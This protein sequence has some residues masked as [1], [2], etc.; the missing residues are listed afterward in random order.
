MKNINFILFFTFFIVGFGLFAQDSR[1]IITEE[2]IGKRVT[3]FAE[4][5]SKDTLNIFL[6]IFP[7]GFRRSASQPKLTN[8]AP[9]EKLLMTTL[10]ELGTKPSSYSYELFVNDEEQNINMSFEKNV[11]DIEK[12]ITG[13]VVIFSNDLCEKCDYLSKVLDEKRIA[14]RNFNI[15]EDKVLYNQFLYFIEKKYP[16]KKIAAL[17][18]VWNK[19]YLIFG[20]TDVE[21]VLMQL[22]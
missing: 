7:E 10:I 13:K 17:P 8:I 1:I 22:K 9:K 19:D 18:V 6:M 21:D 15:T 3:V 14:H 5:T 12:V 11:I 4:N 20:Y 2:K 16:N